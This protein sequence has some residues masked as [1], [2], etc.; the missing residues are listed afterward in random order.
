MRLREVDFT[1]A[2]SEGYMIAYFRGGIANGQY[3]MCDGVP[4]G[5]WTL[6]TEDDTLLELHMFNSDAEFRV[7]TRTNGE[8]IYARIEKEANGQEYY[9][10]CMLLHPSKNEPL[11]QCLVVRSHISYDENDMIEIK[12]YRL[13]DVV[14]VGEE[15]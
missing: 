10:E 14:P 8:P 13:V 6:Q 9:E 1:N 7:V 4:C 12:N 15:E 11:Q 3:R 2:P 5:D